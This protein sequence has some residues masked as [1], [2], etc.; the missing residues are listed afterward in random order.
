MIRKLHAALRNLYEDFEKCFVKLGSQ[1]LL[2]F[3]VKVSRV[4]PSTFLE[5][6]IQTNRL[7]CVIVKAYHKYIYIYIYIYMYI[8]NVCINYI[9]C[10]TLS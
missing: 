7:F 1:F 6:I 9:W 4:F 8:Y 5:I 10:L 2:K 3:H